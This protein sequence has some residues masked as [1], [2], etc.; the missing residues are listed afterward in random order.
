MAALDLTQGV[1]NRTQRRIHLLALLHTHSLTGGVEHLANDAVRLAHALAAQSGQAHR[2]TILN[3]R[4]TRVVDLDVAAL[5][6]TR[7]LLDDVRSEERRVGKE[8]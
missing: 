5:L 1:E 6:Q 3:G 2:G 8:C 7:E 4:I